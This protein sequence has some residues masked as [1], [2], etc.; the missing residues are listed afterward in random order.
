M[1]A[2]APPSPAKRRKLALD[3]AYLEHADSS[4]TSTQYSL[5]CCPFQIGRGDHC[6]LRLRGK[7]VSRT[8]AVMS[9]TD[10][11]EWEIEDRSTNGLFVNESDQRV[12]LTRPHVLADGER[13]RVG[14]PDGLLVVYHAQPPP[15]PTPQSSQ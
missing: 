4:G 15:P 3:S 8:H 12:P 2:P 7:L 5:T 1:D 6:H 14:A 11:G 13:L 9:V 10:S